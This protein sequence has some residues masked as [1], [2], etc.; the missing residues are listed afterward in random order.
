MS[1]LTNNGNISIYL[2]L[3]D[4]IQVRETMYLLLLQQCTFKKEKDYALFLKAFFSIIT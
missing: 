1:I 4:N 3:F 2:N